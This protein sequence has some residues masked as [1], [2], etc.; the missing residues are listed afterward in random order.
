MTDG[1]IGK[2]TCFSNGVKRR[3]T[4][5]Q[6]EIKDRPASSSILVIIIIIIIQRET[7]RQALLTGAFPQS[8]M[9]L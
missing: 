9:F 7:T 8:Y 6:W 5:K 2:I 4:K 3:S 1:E